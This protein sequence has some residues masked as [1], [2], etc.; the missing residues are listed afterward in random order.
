MRAAKISEDALLVALPL[1]LVFIQIC[2]GIPD[3]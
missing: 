2:L 3:V 1:T